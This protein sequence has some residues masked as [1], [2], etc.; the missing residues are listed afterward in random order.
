MRFF[1]T[2]GPVKADLH[3]CLPPLGRVDLDDILRLIA[4]Q[5]YFI[6]HAPRQV[7]KTSFL[8]A[9]MDYLNREGQYK[10]LYLNVESAQ[11]ARENV[12]KGIQTILSEMASRAQLFLDDD[13]LTVI[14]EYIVSKLS[15][16]TSIHRYVP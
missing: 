11:A 15:E 8:L 7:G 3:Y 9:L 6:L 4:Q 2:A 14:P 16:K 12:N 1:N 10:A 5:K 13:Y